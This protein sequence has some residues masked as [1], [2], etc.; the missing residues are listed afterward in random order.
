MV[1]YL[2]QD[3]LQNSERCSEK[4]WLSLETSFENNDLKDFCFVANGPFI[5]MEN[6]G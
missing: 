1:V 6:L 4:P 3:F 5:L 2:L